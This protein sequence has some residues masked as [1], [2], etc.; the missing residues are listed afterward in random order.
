MMGHET[1]GKRV[2]VYIGERDKAEGRHDPL[3]ETLLHFLRD[4]GAA[5]A[6]MFRGL[7][8]FGAHSKIHTARLADLVPDLPVVVEWVDNAE[9]VQRLLPKINELVTHGTIT[10]EAVEIVRYSPHASQQ[11]AA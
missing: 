10:V 2:R 8:G 9:Q 11:P 6:T 5:G 4:E 1:Q 7:A 3:W